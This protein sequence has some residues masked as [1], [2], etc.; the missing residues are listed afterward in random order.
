[1]IVWGCSPNLNLKG[2]AAPRIRKALLG[3][4]LDI[5]IIA[6]SECFTAMEVKTF[7]KKFG[8]DMI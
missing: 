8:R 3:E 5:Y 1:M 4:S 2:V 6:E 7:G